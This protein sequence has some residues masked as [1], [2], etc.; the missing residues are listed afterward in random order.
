MKLTTFFIRHPVIAV[1]INALLLL[2]GLLSFKHI[3]VREYPEVRLPVFSV[4]VAYPNA[5]AELVESVVISRLEDQLSGLENLDTITSHADQGRAFV[6]L[7]FKPG[8]SVEKAMLDTRDAVGLARADLPIEAEEP[9]IRRSSDNNG[10]PFMAIALSSSTEGFGE[11][12]HYAEVF[13]KNAFRSLPGV[14]RIQIWGRPYTLEIKL[15]LPKMVGLGVNVDDVYQALKKRD[16]HWPLGKFEDRIPVTLNAA[17]NTVDDFNQILI[18][19]KKGKAIYLQSIADIALKTENKQLRVRINGQAGLV[20]AISKTADANPLKVSD[21][22]QKTVKELDSQLPNTMRLSV[23]LDQADFIRASLQNIESSIIEAIVLVL[24]IV[25]LFLRNLRATIIPLIAIPISLIG[26]IVFLKILGFS[27]NTITL[28]AMILA[29]G[30]VVDDAIVILENIT[31]HIEA[32]L[33]VMEA[34]IKGSREIGFAIVAMTFTLASVYCPIAF[35]QGAVGQLFIEFAVALAGSVILSGVVA[36][37][38]SPVM[39]A[40]LLKPATEKNNIL[41]PGIDRTLNAIEKSYGKGLSWVFKHQKMMLLLLFGLLVCVFLLFNSL[42][43]ETAPKEDRG[44]IGVYVPAATG[45]HIDDQEK[46]IV[47]IEKKVAPMI[48]EAAGFLTFLGDW[49]ANFIVNL[50]PHAARSRRA[51]DMVKD[52]QPLMHTLP[53]TDAYVWSWDS[54]LPGLEDALS[55]AELS[56]VVSTVGSYRDLLGKVDAAKK[57][58]E[59]TGEFLSVRHDL[60]LDNPGLEVR[61]NENTLSRLGLTVGDVAK[62]ISTFLSGDQSLKFTRDGIRYPITLEAREKPQGL[63]DLYLT[64]PSGKSVSVGAF[65]EWKRVSMPQKMNHYNQ[66]RSAYLTATMKESDRLPEKMSRFRAVVDSVIPATF[67]K[68]WAGAAKA[69][70]EDSAS[71][72][73]LFGMAIVFIYAILSMQFENFIDPFII[74]CTVPLGCFGALLMAKGFHQSLNIYTQIGLVTLI[75]L[76]TKHGILIVEFANQ[77]L[78][79]GQGLEASVRQAA[80]LRLRPILMTTAAMV[81]GALPLIISGG[82]GTE[83]RHAIGFVLVGG[84]LFG[85]LLTL[86]LLPTVYCWVKRVVLRRI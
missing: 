44:L 53:S 47:Q 37:S 50:K 8:T 55:G 66:M 14:S 7:T 84:L 27:I 68:T 64:T 52:V 29:I 4:E 43:S 57:A 12:N 5:S 60:T 9:R 2:L 35:I 61:V 54:G 70:Q 26:G 85:T 49:G 20:L 58:L 34:A 56:L 22:V 13:L 67:K 71:L 10:P 77:C 15:D 38:L 83:A 17:L 28:L 81:L 76:I 45:R 21:A 65:A 86:F 75:G 80:I 31:R 40:Y 78:S 33:T 1:V 62:T 6:Q 36:L 3:P 39:C 46:I 73:L 63:N 74:L 72:L 42:P 30:L 51:A 79:Q 82:A 32:G 24:V 23:V 16:L 48:P 11:L 19:E 59:D 25:F 18:T 41:W 69:Y